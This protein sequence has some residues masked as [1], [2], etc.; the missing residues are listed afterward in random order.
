MKVRQGVVLREPERY[1]MIP[2]GTGFW[3]LAFKVAY[4]SKWNPGVLER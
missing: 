4:V 1:F 3:E 2:G